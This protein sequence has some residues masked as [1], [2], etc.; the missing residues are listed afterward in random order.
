M[1]TLLKLGCVALL[2]GV[3]L[4]PYAV[5]PFDA[6]STSCQFGLGIADLRELVGRQ[7]VGECLENQSYAANGDAVQRIGLYPKLDAVVTEGAAWLPLYHPIEPRVTP[8]KHSWVSAHAI[9]YTPRN[10]SLT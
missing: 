9:F 7:K 8:K 5:A 10:P 6:Q 1:G 3:A 2:G 4:A